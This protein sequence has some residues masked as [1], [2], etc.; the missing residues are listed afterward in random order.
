MRFRE[1]P[2]HCNRRLVNLFIRCKKEEMSK[3]FILYQLKKGLI[4]D[5]YNKK[6]MN[7]EEKFIVFLSTG[8][9]KYKYLLRIE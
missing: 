5:L 6:I 8:K 2:L 9:I 1:V 3:F 4:M 7:K